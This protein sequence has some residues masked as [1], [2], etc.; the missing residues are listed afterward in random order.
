[1]ESSLEV[2]TQRELLKQEIDELIENNLPAKILQVA[3]SLIQRLTRRSNLPPW[4]VST[5]L[6]G[7][8][9]ILPQLVITWILKDP[10]QII[11]KE[12]PWS[13]STE[14]MIL[15]IPAVYFLLK[16]ILTM[17]RDY[18]VDDIEEHENL[19]KFQEF[20]SEIGKIPRAIVVVVLTSVI[21]SSV[22]LPFLSTL[23]ALNLGVFL[24]VS[25]GNC[26]FGLILYFMSWYMRF[27]SQL[28]NY[29]YKLYKLDPAKSKVINYIS[30]IL[31]IPF[32][33]GALFQAMLILGLSF[34]KDQFKIAAQ[35]TIVPLFF[36]WIPLIVHFINSQM[37]INKIITTAKWRMLADLQS[38][39]HQQYDKPNPQLTQN[40]DAVNKLMDLHERLYN[41]YNSRLVTTRILSLINQLLIPLLTFIITNYDFVLGLFNHKLKP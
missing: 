5:T 27:P 1:M 30:Y 7:V 22:V 2:S 9:A 34:F 11:G 29:Q 8:I 17:I 26:A 6:L 14:A 39:I 24:A 12:L 37:A 19:I 10:E 35:I 4:Y 15:V 13:I 20:L 32:L 16:Y 41:T 23:I 25:I 31:T 21:W 33:V 3:G 36:I 40:I 38:Q 18:I 28:G